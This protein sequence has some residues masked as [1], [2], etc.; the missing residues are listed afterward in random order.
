MAACIFC[1]RDTLDILAETSLSFAIRDKFPVRPLHTL[2]LSKRHVESAFDLTEE[3]FHDIF[4]L[5]N[6]MQRR[7]R[8]EDATVAGFNFGSN[9]GAVAG[10]KI[11]HV[12]FHLIPRREG[13]TPPPPAEG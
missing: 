1:D 13:D 3:E 5:S 9:V 7:L 2:I 12:H 11:M 8:S 6:Q 4:R 10:Q